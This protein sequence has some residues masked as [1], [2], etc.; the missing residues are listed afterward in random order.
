MK[1]YN[2]DYSHDSIYFEESV[3]T[4]PASKVFFFLIFYVIAIDEWWNYSCYFE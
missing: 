3:M 2:Q 4:T 1:E